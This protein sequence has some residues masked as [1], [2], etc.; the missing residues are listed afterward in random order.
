MLMAGPVHVYA[1]YGLYWLVPS[2]RVWDDW[3]PSCP[4][5]LHV[6]VGVPLLPVLELERTL[7]A[8]LLHGTNSCR[9]L[10]VC[11]CVTL[12]LRRDPSHL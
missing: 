9:C 10:Q 2:G 11:V 7:C 3:L 12:P 6:G 1:C 8:A 5:V 4:P